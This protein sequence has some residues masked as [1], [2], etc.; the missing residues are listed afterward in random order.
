VS[1]LALRNIRLLNTFNFC[2]DFRIYAPI[3]VVYFA[4]VTGSYALAVLLFSIAKISST[5]LEVPTGLISDRVGRRLTIIAGQAASILSVGC[6]AFGGDFRALAAGAAFE[7]LAFSCF[8][9]NNE[10]LLYDTLKEEGR[11]DQYADYQGRASSMFQIALAISAALAAVVLLGFGM[12]QLFVLSLIPQ[13]IGLAVAF[14]FHEPAQHDRRFETNIFSHLSEAFAAFAHNARLRELSIASI[15][16]FAVG[17]A[18][19]MFY[20]AFF[21]L[22]WPSW[23]LGVAG[24]ITHGLATLG[25]RAAGRLVRR[26]GELRVLLWSSVASKAFLLS[27]LVVPN[28]TSPAV[29]SLASLLFG[30]NVIAQGSLMQK[31]F[32]DA[33]RATMASLIA[34]GGNLLFAVA[35]YA[36][37]ALADRVGPRYALLTAEIL[38]ISVTLLYWRL[39]RSVSAEMGSKM[40]EDQ[41]AQR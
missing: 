4:H 36:L 24:F 27:A 14:L 34:F 10:A 5:I 41:A 3:A 15:L 40:H 37:G 28:V 16:G 21:A 25:F 33:Q 18:N 6:Y 39:Y 26:F 31:G 29:S 30:P 22:L 23:A 7:G 38:A 35:V 17:E 20:P 13:T 11:H 19:H 12:R 9:G 2:S 32:T 8:S 1:P